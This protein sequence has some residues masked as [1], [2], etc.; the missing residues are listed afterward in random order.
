MKFNLDWTGGLTLGYS[1]FN[2]WTFITSISPASVNLWLG[3]IAGLL[4]LIFLGLSKYQKY[5]HQQNLND[6]EIERLK[7]ELDDEFPKP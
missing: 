7:R 3:V 1:G 6:L 2:L 5:K 4:G